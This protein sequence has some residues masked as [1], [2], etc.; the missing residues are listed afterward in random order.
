MQSIITGITTERESLKQDPNCCERMPVK[1]TATAAIFW[2]FTNIEKKCSCNSYIINRPFR[3]TWRPTTCPC[4]SSSGIW[5]AQKC[6]W[7]CKNLTNNIARSSTKNNV[8]NGSRS[9]ANISWFFCHEYSM[10][11]WGLHPSWS[12]FCLE[13][14]REVDLDDLTLWSI[15]VDDIGHRTFYEERNSRKDWESIT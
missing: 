6:I 5:K 14:E 10:F 4:N 15:V 7:D 13:Q 8:T 12:M 9:S 3:P 2:T 1:L 11:A